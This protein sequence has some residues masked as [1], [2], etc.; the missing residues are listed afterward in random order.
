[1]NKKYIILL[2]TIIFICACL[3]IFLRK[4]NVK[5]M[6]KSDNGNNTS[7]DYKMINEINKTQTDNFMISPVSIAYALSMLKEGATENTKN[8]LDNVLDNYKLPQIPNIK[9]RISLAN[10]LFINNKYKK[11]INKSYIK[12]LQDGYDSDLM[13]DS[14]NSPSKINDWISNKTFKMIPKAIDSISPSTV[15]GLANAIAI[16]VKWMNEFECDNTREKEF[17]LINNEKMTIPMMHSSNDVTYIESDNAKGIIKDYKVYNTLTGEESYEEDKNNIS[18]EY[19]AI[20]PN[21]NIEEYKNIF[22][23]EELNKLL[24]NKQYANN[25]LD[26]YYSLPKYTYDFDYQGFKEALINMGIKE[27]FT[28]VASFN[29]MKNE[30]SKLQLYVSDAI[31]KSHIELNETGTKAA[32]VTVFMLKDGA[33]PFEEEKKIINISFNKPFVYIIKEKESDNIWFYGIVYKPM[34]FKDNPKCEVEYR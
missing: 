32:A 12:L 20:L 27:M 17:T 31:H 34:D 9:N 21:T 7:F 2:I 4:E 6:N 24:S 3:F 15:L 8:E 25:K 5:P 33:M 18:L 1:M 19:I 10:L 23:K 28:P 29:K 22:N 14:F 13:F 11:D 30:E 26:I 16:D